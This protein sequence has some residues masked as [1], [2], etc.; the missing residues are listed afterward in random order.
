MKIRWNI[1][2]SG[3]CFG[4]V[5]GVQRGDVMEIDDVLGKAYIEAGHAEAVRDHH[6]SE[7]RAEEHATLPRSEEHATLPHKEHHDDD[8]PHAKVGV[9]GVD[10]GPGTVVKTELREAA[11]FFDDPEP[12][13]EAPVYGE[14]HP[15]ED[16][17]EPATS[18]RQP[19]AR[20]KAA[21]AK[22]AAAE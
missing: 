12:A 14:T 13:A 19:T 9:D 21:A 8:V 4:S 7:H 22:K 10:Q 20:A 11:G 3:Q 18:K 1:N 17:P 15:P 16:A 2:V 5:N 6:A